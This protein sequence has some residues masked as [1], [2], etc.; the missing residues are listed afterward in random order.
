VLNAP[1]NRKPRPASYQDHYRCC[2]SPRRCRRVAAANDRLPTET[3][4]LRNGPGQPARPPLF[5][6]GTA[7]H[8]PGPSG[9][10][11]NIR[12]SFRRVWRAPDG[13]QTGRRCSGHWTVWTGQP[14][15]PEFPTSSESSRRRRCVLTLTYSGHLFRRRS[16]GQ[17][18]R[19]EFPTSSTLE[20]R[21]LNGALTTW[22]TCASRTTARVRCPGRSSS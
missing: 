6:S 9:L 10:D 12:R 19:P 20:R 22:W 15:Q 16:T 17:P 8:R 14:H 21:R 4:G 7:D 2:P 1:L 13:V 3:V 18:R 11:R 5:H